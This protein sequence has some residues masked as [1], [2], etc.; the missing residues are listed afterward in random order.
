MKYSR[1]AASLVVASFACGGPPMAGINAWTYDD[2]PDSGATWAL[3]VHPTNSNIVLASTIRGLYRTTNAGATWTLVSEAITAG[4]TSIAFDPTHPDRVFA[5]SVELFRSNDAGATWFRQQTL[6][7]GP[8]RFVGFTNAGTLY[9]HSHTA[10]VRRSINQGTTWTTCGAPWG[11]DVASNAFTVAPAAPNHLYIEILSGDSAIRG[12]WRSTDGCA[13]WT[14]SGSGNPAGGTDGLVRRYAVD[15][16]DSNNVLAASDLGVMRSTNAGATWTNQFAGDIWW[17]DFEP[18]TAGVAYA[19]LG[20]S[21][22]VRSTD[23]GDNW[24]NRALINAVDRAKVV[25]DPL[26]GGRLWAATLNGPYLSSDSAQTF[27]SR[28]SGM[29]AGVVYNFAAADDGLV[30]A[31]FNQGAGGVFR[32]NPATRVW[33]AVNNTGLQAAALA[34]SPWAMHYVAV[35]PTDSSRVY[36]SVAPYSLMRSVSS[37]AAWDPANSQ[38]PNTSS[39]PVATSVDPDDPLVAYTATSNNH[40]FKTV[41]GGVSWAHLT[42]V[43]FFVWTVLAAPGSDTVYAAAGTTFPTAVWKS[44]NGGTT[45]APTGATPLPAANPNDSIKDLAIDPTNPE[46]VFAIYD[47]AIYRTANGGTSWSLMNFPFGAPMLTRAVLVDPLH[48]TTIMVSSVDGTATLGRTVDGGAT[49]QPVVVPDSVSYRWIQRAVLDP[50]RPHVVI[51]AVGGAGVGE[52]EFATDLQLSVSG[53]GSVLPTSGAITGTITIR[54][55]GPHAASPSVFTLTFPT[56]ATPTPLPPGCSRTGQQITCAIPSLQVG[57]SHALQQRI[58]VSPAGGVGNLVATVTP[59][60][61]ELALADN[62]LTLPVTT[63]ELADLS[64]TL[65]PSPPSLAIEETATVTAVVRNDGPSPSTATTLAV[66]VPAG[67]TVISATPSAGSCTTLASSATC[68]LGTISNANSTSVVVHVRGVTRGSHIVNGSADGAG[69]DSDVDQSATATLIVVPRSNVR[70]TLAES[71]D[72]VQ[73]LDNFTHTA[74]VTNE[75]P[76]SNDITLQLQLNT[77]TVAQ[78]TSNAGVCTRVDFIVTCQFLALASGASGTATVTFNSLGPAIVTTSAGASFI[79]RDNDYSDNVAT[80][81]TTLRNVADVGLEIASAPFAV[82]GTPHYVTISARNA[83]PNRVA[84]TI[85]VAMTGASI[86]SVVGDGMNCT[87]SAATATCTVLELAA[88]ALRRSF[89]VVVDPQAS[90]AV[91]ATATV[92]IDGFDPAAANDT[93]TETKTIR[94][95]SDIAVELADSAD[96][97]VNGT[98]FNYLATVRNLGTVAGPVQLAFDTAGVTVTAASVPGGSCGITASTVLC[99]IASLA[100]GA[101][102]VVTIAMATPNSTTVTA[103]ATA[104]YQGADPVAANNT[105]STTTTISSGVASGGSSS[106]G[107]KGGG[108]GRFDWLGLL[109]LAALAAHAAAR[110]RRT[111]SMA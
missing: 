88:G 70:V 53:I 11:P 92:T 7:D 105:A 111:R 74:T 93:A 9:A 85:N 46:V 83:G 44:T 71:A 82:A 10:L 48:P 73:V 55:A 30:Y 12:T 34:G 68:N 97:V 96:P 76:D 107:G 109:L 49:W 51:A 35:A 5:G 25:A 64:L 78:V 95:T 50:L 57:A 91:T 22:V 43:P 38:F 2:G 6:D 31:V 15:P 75:G 36:A 24:A 104:T 8:F 99:D 23:G 16:N 101:N 29:R 94:G 86:T 87:S 45:W 102:V 14:R 54:N 37:G 80:I 67:L 89:T 13:T 106:G 21:Q 20:H 32:R 60:E 1:I 3:T 69:T 18:A 56:W 62:S 47:T 84:A 77:T 28:Q 98:A 4:N 40:V 79:G 33:S 90:G 72:P 103:N 59:H 110:E 81:G 66:T 26:I 19:T 63:T 27:T 58:A 42:N 61:A 100:G 17:V 41:D 65:T 52:Y 108:G 39:I